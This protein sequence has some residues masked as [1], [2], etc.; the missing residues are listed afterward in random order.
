[1]TIDLQQV[2]NSS[3][4]LHLVSSFAKNIPPSLGYGIARRLAD[5]IARQRNSKVVQ[6]VRANQWVANGESLQGKALDDAVR[7]T[8]RYSAHSLFDLYHYGRDFESTGRLIDF[9]PSF[10]LIAKRPEPAR[11]GLMIAGLHLS[12]FD[13]VLQWL[14]QDG[15]RPLVLTLPDPKGARRTEF[16][17]RKRIGMN[18]LPASVSAFRKALKHLQKGGMVL[19]GIDRPIEKPD[20]YP[21]FFGRPA[22]LPVHH[23][24]LAIKACV[25]VVIAAAYLRPDGKYHVFASELIEMDP[26]RDTATAILQNAEKVLGVAEILIRRAPLQWSV[27]LQ[28]WPQ[29]VDI[30]PE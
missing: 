7:E 22:A 16:E 29:I 17:I 3:L 13:L 9:D 10:D 21:R 18:L 12:S 5:R 14:C 19:T 11:R 27:P 25:P 1:M 23:V 20:V 8:L 28:V 6:A 2:L 24:F 4:S 26:A 15:L 30:V